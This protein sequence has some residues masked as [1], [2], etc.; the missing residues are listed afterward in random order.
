MPAALSILESSGQIG[1]MM[2]GPQDSR[3]CTSESAEVERLAAEQ[4]AK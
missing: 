3:R 1:N 2:M 4:Q